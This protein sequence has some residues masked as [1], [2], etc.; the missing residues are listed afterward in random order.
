MLDYTQISTQF[1][2]VLT[3]MKEEGVEDNEQIFKFFTY[4]SYIY[5]MK[6]YLTFTI[7]V[8]RQKKIQSTQ[9]RKRKRKSQTQITKEK[10]QI[11]NEKRKSQKRKR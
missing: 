5:A 11:T 6:I 10:T 2:F 1:I 8:F 9:S 4:F 3:D 7:H